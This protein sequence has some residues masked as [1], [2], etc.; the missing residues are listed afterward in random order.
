MF[1]LN[2][3]QWTVL[4]HALFAATGPLAWILTKQLGLSTED[5]KMWLEFLAAVTPIW[6][7]ALMARNRSTENQGAAIAA[8]NPEDKLKAMAKVPAGA[9]IA[10]AAAVPGTTIVV[11]TRVAPDSAVHAAEDDTLP[12][13]L[14]TQ[15]EVKV[16]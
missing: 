4:K 14:P 11:N 3:E 2:T 1:G 16:Q 6:A 10:A 8:M 5:T 12:N 13:V 9:K 7:T 15:E